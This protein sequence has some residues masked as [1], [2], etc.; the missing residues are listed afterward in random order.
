MRA[1]ATLFMY[2]TALPVATQGVDVNQTCE[3]FVE[4]SV[5]RCTCAINTKAVSGVGSSRCTSTV[6]Y[7]ELVFSGGLGPPRVFCE[8]SDY[9]LGLVQSTIKDSSFLSCGKVNDGNPEVVTLELKLL[10]H[11]PALR[12]SDFKCDLNCGC[13]IGS[14]CL[15]TTQSGIPI[16]YSPDC[17]P[18]ITGA[19]CNLTCHPNCVGGVCGRADGNCTIPNC[20]PG[21]YGTMCNLTCKPDCNGGVCGREDGNCINCLPG[22]YGTLCNLTCHPNCMGGLCGRQEGNCIN[23]KSGGKYGAWCNLTCPSDCEGRV[24][25]REEGNCT[26]IPPPEEKKDNTLA[27]ALGV[28][29]PG[30]VALLSWLCWCCSNTSTALSILEV[31]GCGSAERHSDKSSE[32]NESDQDK[33]S[34]GGSSED[35][36][37]NSDGD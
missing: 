2:I 9:Y 12:G 31:L 4:N 36:S 14:S 34:Q 17:A 1:W 26:L 11:E 18:G 25:G 13:G 6:R 5:S 23:C 32:S 29:I 30:L 8:F 28:G 16:Q 20:L 15:N 21:E 35:V 33:I 37:R 19:K 24:C 10:S 27:I 22:K 3:P 7:V